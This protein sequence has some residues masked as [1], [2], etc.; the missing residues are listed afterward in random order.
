M[1]RYTEQKHFRR[2][3]FRTQA[4]P[5]LS[6]HQ[7]EQLRPTV[8]TAIQ[9]MNGLRETHGSATLSLAKTPSASDKLC[10]MENSEMSDNVRSGSQTDI[11]QLQ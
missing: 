3:G 4:E 9:R 5:K 6:A 11:T 8:R 2:T 7:D 10:S 1:N